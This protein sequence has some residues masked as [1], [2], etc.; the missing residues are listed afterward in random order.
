MKKT[1]ER[2]AVIHTEKLEGRAV[3]CTQSDE[4]CNSGVVQS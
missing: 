4:T 3:V 1:Y 2:P